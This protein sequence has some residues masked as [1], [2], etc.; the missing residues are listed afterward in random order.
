M[1]QELIDAKLYAYQDAIDAL[2]AQES[3]SDNKYDINARKWLASKL[4]KE[5]ERWLNKRK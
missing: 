2:L 5:C 1:K 3:A 4:N